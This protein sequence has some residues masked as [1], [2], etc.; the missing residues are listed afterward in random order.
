MQKLM[1]TGALLTAMS[2][3]AQAGWKDELGKAADAMGMGEN[4]EQDSSSSN[5][6][7]S[8]LGETEIVEGLKEALAKGTERAIVSLGQTDGYWTNELVKIAMP[9]QL[10]SVEKPMRSF[11]AGSYVD[12][13]HMTLN[14]AAETAVPEVAD[15]F[16]NAIRALTVEDAR[17]ILN[18]AD[19][20]ATQYFK[21]SST[22][23]LTAKIKPLV[24]EATDKVG[25]TSSYKSLIGQAGPLAAML[26]P[27][28]ADL[29]QYVTNEALSGL[30]KTLAKEEGEIRSNPAARTTDIL[31]RVFGGK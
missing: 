1:I 4:S 29:D 12:E 6:A 28:A 27:N 9:D 20:A 17:A 15:I 18:G 26:D 22:E 21:R 25:L 8:A 19:D 30:F 2:I 3:P 16:G 31:E 24:A 5:M 10:K 14:R 7:M 11:G 13:F 23:A